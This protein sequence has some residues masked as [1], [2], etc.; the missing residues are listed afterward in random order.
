MHILIRIVSFEN[1]K[2]QKVLFTFRAISDAQF[3]EAA[4]FVSSDAQKRRAVALRAHQTQ[5]ICDER[6]RLALQHEGRDSRASTASQLLL[7]S[8]NGFLARHVYT[9]DGAH[10]VSIA[11]CEV[12]HGGRA[13]SA[14]S[15]DHLGSWNIDSTQRIDSFFPSDP[16][17]GVLQLSPWLPGSAARSAGRCAVEC[18]RLAHSLLCA[19]LVVAAPAHTPEYRALRV[20]SLALCT[21]GLLS[22]AKCIPCKRV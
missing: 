17:C 21:G 1:Q 20:R 3:G 6:S 18:I 22:V 14:S 12:Q 11:A 15:S 16:A 7:A 4:A 2:D 13:Q 9:M 19:P 8:C 10:P 5:R